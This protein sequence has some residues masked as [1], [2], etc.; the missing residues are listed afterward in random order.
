VFAHVAFPI[1]VR[2]TFAYSVPEEAAADCRV[3]VEVL[4]P[5]G[6]RARRGV[7][8]ALSAAADVAAERVKPLTRVLSPEPVGK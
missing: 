8:V 7:V 6:A 5:F 1:P 4:A 3:G 2:R